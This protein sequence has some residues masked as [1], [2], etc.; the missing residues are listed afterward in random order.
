M[1]YKFINSEIGHF[2]FILVQF[3]VNGNADI[4]SLLS[5]LDCSTE[6]MQAQEAPNGG[7]LARFQ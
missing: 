6:R 3:Q 1:C 7:K 5:D 2:Y 4:E